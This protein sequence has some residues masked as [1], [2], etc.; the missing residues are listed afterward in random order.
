MK[1]EGKN[2]RIPWVVIRPSQGEDRGP[3]P[4]RTRPVRIM[5][6]QVTPPSLSLGAGNRGSV[7]AMRYAG[8]PL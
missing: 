3:L 4:L 7:R 5:T 1:E 8:Y 2:V 6:S